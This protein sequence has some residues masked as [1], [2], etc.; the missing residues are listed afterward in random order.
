MCL[1]IAA[2]CI[3]AG[4]GA[5]R[6]GTETGWEQS[7]TITPNSLSQDDAVVKLSPAAVGGQKERMKTTIR[8]TGKGFSK[9]MTIELNLNQ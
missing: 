8:A 9:E 7:M 1:H 4:S 6:I 2:G 5:E 3:R